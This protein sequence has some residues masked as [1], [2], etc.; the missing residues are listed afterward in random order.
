MPQPTQR[1]LK[2]RTQIVRKLGAA[3]YS[4]RVQSTRKNKKRSRRLQ[5]I[6]GDKQ[7]PVIT[8]LEF[9]TYYS[10]VLHYISF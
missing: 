7:R 10:I 5:A 2:P 4:T 6:N 1:Q 9:I 3:E 8:V